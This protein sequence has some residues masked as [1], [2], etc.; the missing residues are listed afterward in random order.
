MYYSTYVDMVYFFVN[1]RFVVEVASYRDGL[2][3]LT[4]S[5][6]NGMALTST[7]VCTCGRTSYVY[8]ATSIIHS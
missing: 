2:T 4:D 8:V 6:L 5:T 7:I 1:C 3:P